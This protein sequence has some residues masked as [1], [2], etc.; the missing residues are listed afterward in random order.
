M[1]YAKS[2][3]AKAE[4]KKNGL[5]WLIVLIGLLCPLTT[6][7]STYRVADVPNVQLKDRTRFVSN[8]DGI[9]SPTAQT[10]VDSLLSHIRQASTAEAV[11]VV[12]GDIEPQDI[13]GFATELFNAWGLGKKDNNNGVLVLVA[14]DA[15]RA[16]IRTGYGVEGV[17]PDIL[18]G[19]ILR[20]MFDHFRNG[21]F[22][23]GA[24][25]AAEQIDA[26]LTDPAAAEE[27]RSSQKD[28]YRDDEGNP[29]VFYL[30]FALLLSG[31]CLLAFLFKLYSLRKVQSYDKYAALESWRAP[32]L[33]LTFLTLGMLLVV[34]LPLVI[35]LRHWRNKP[36][37]CPN[38]GAKMTKLDEVHDNDYLTPAQDLEE[39]LGSVDYDVWLCPQCNERDI[40]PFVNK[41]STMTECEQCHART[42]PM[43]VDRI[44]RQPT[45]S[46][47]GMGVR[48]YHCLHC[49]HITRRAYNIAKVAPV[50]ILPMGGGSRGGGGGSFGGGFGGGMTG[51]G[52]A[53][54]GW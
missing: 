53:S 36:R 31:G 20:D 11:M 21:D 7:A 43:K 4:K 35:M 12:V 32:M 25:T 2:S 52:G 49:G 54:G 13:D 19:R 30:T 16:T 15:R 50:V 18:C 8:P 26:L 38:C 17:L 6:S 51:G 27:I 22:D 42:A 48:E 34:S 14:K 45:V 46:K 47:E 37:I 5:I 41:K 24:I 3:Q 9:L 23:A 29:F 44:V 40:Y 33:A 10:R 39:R 28:N 1:T